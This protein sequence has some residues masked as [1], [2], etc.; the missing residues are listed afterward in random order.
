MYMKLREWINK[1]K[2]YKDVLNS[3]PNSIRYIQEFDIIDIYM[4][5]GNKNG[6]EILRKNKLMNQLKSFESINNFHVDIPFNNLQNPDVK[7][8]FVPF[9]N[10]CFNKNDLVGFI[11]YI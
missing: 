6:I 11:N 4:L 3:N 1:E 5:S 9:R 2:L 10:Q 8:G 7:E